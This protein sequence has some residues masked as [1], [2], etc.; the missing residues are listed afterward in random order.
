VPVNATQ[1]KSALSHWGSG[2]TV[3]T[4]RDAAHAPVGMTASAFASLSL[5]P[6]L[7]LFC[8]GLDS[9]GRE[10]FVAAPGFTVHLLAAGQETLS[11]RFAARGGD[12]FA[13]LEYGAGRRGPL[14]PG[15]LTVLECRTHAQL[16]GGDH[17]IMVGE[18]ESVTVGD[19]EPLLY[20]R[21]R[22]RRFG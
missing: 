6:P 18:V 4:T 13:G 21:G 15:C 2:V 9:T 7:V 14:L 1:F 22:Y 17:I 20:F 12:K 8:L 11:A 5:E 10:A 16:P 19:G 3:I